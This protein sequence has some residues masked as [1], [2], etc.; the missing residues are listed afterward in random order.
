MDKIKLLNDDMS[1]EEINKFIEDNHNSSDPEVVFV[2]F[3]FRIRSSLYHES[4]YK[5]YKDNHLTIEN[6]DLINGS[7]IFLNLL[8]FLKKDDEAIDM[9]PYYQNLPYVNQETEEYLRNLNHV[10]MD[11]IKLRDKPNNETK[12]YDVEYYK[13]AFLKAQKLEE[14]NK[15]VAELVSRYDDLKLPECLEIFNFA[16]ENKQNDPMICSLLVFFLILLESEK[17]IVFS[18]NGKI[19]SF[20]PKDKKEEINLTIKVIK[21]AADYIRKSEKNMTVSSISREFTEYSAQFFFPDYLTLDDLDNFIAAV[22]KLANDLAGEDYLADPLY[23][24]LKINN[25]ERDRFINKLTLICL[26]KEKN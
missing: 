17:N 8:I 16:F 9:V 5:Y 26:K 21:E 7:F 20:A 24:S 11:L 14:V 19:Y 25:A 15:L 12:K 2:N 3:I 1:Q 13:N 10:V 22:L 18:M 6:F 23:E 4:A